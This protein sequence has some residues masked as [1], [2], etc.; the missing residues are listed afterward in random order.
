MRFCA[1]FRQDDISLK[2]V[3]IFRKIHS[4]FLWFSYIFY[5]LHSGTDEG[6]YNGLMLEDNV[7]VNNTWLFTSH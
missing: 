3:Y 5:E 2:N 7:L 6:F 1:F 4:S